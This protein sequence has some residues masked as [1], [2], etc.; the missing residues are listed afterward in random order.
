MSLT[1]L[2][3][4]PITVALEGTLCI[5]MTLC[6][7]ILTLSAIPA[8]PSNLAHVSIKTLFPM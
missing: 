4:E 6:A 1:I 2:A 7:P 8:D 3:G 5:T